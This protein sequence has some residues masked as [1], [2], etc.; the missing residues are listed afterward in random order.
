[1]RDRDTADR[2][3]RTTEHRR[4]VRR[5]RAAESWFAD[6]LLSGGSHRA[7]AASA[8]FCPGRL[9]QG[10]RATGRRARSLQGRIHD[11]PGRA[12]PDRT[13]P[14]TSIRLASERPL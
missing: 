9:S 13:R 12:C 6:V 5:E 8:G 14:T 2:D 1:M 11:V 4:P 3:Q 10:R 7:R